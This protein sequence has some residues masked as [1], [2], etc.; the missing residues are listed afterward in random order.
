MDQSLYRFLSVIHQLITQI[1]SHYASRVMTVSHGSHLL[2]FFDFFNI[3]INSGIRIVF[4]EWVSSV[5][6][7]PLSTCRRVPRRLFALNMLL[8]DK[9]KQILVYSQNGR[10]CEFPFSRLI[11]FL[12]FSKIIAPW[13]V[14]MNPNTM[15][16]GFKLPSQGLPK[17]NV[18]DEVF[19]D[20]R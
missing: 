15:N 19:H 1:W 18:L 3:H 9:D 10:T 11:S 13:T 8:S 20:Y 12:S 14:I 2:F 4:F 6:N 7:L 17:Q 16:T 5:A